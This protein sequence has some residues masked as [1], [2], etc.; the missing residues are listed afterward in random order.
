MDNGKII[1]ITGASKNIGAAIAKTLG[2][3]NTVFLISRNEKSLQQVENEIN[4]SLGHALAIKCDVTNESNITNTIAQVLSQFGHI[5]VHIN[6]AGFAKVARVD[7]FTLTDYNAIFDVNVKG[8]FL[9]TKYVVPHFITQ[10]SGQ[11]INIASSAGLSGFKG[12]TLYSSSKFAV[13]GFSESLREDL[14]QH[15]IAVSVICP[16]TVRTDNPFKPKMQYDLEPADVARTVAY[17]VSEAETANTLLIHLQ[18]RRRKEFRGTPD[19]V[20]IPSVGEKTI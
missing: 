5:D 7:E 18:P 14:K 15:G 2:K 1:L 20:F 3:S 9:F 12:G 6:N 10:Q 19:A 8:M 11:I 4:E 16:G 13:I 17:L